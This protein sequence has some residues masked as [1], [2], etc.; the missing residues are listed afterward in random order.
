MGKKIN[1]KKMNI[2]SLKQ[3]KER[4]QIKKLIEGLD[5]FLELKVL[6][7]KFTNQRK[8]SN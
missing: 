4:N 8:C 1:A 2:S 6:K 3:D 5:L 7:K